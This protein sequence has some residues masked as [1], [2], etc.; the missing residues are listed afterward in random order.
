MK[1][2][3]LEQ[4]GFRTETYT[5][6]V[7]NEETGELELVEKTREV[8]NMVAITREMTEEEKQSLIVDNRTYEEKIVA[9]IREKY[10]IDDELAILR[11][12]DTKPNDFNEYNTF[13]E[14]IKREVKG[15]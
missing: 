8:P 3:V 12:R 13:V 15:E 9:K 1:I 14:N 6:E 4:Q 10:S 7:L 5:E 11:Q 2:N